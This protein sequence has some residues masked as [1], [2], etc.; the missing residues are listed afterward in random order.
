MAVTSEGGPSQSLHLL[1]WGDDHTGGQPPVPLPDNAAHH[2]F[3]ERLPLPHVLAR[4]T[5]ADSL[6]PLSGK[7]PVKKGAKGSHKE[8]AWQ[9]EVAFQV[10]EMAGWL[11]ERCPD[12]C[13]L[14]VGPHQLTPLAL[15]VI[16]G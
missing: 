8:R 6:Q 13:T 4:L 16:R 10:L 12:A 7:A 1:L 15:A 9:Q 14:Q 2:V 11:V 5:W 3:V